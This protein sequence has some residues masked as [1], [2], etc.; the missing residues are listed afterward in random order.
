[1]LETLIHFSFTTP[2]S[3]LLCACDAAEPLEV[4]QLQ[5]GLLA[6]ATLTLT[7][8]VSACSSITAWTPASL[9]TDQEGLVRRLAL[10]GASKRSAAG[11]AASCEAGLVSVVESWLC[12]ISSAC[13]QWLKCMCALYNIQYNSWLGGTQLAMRERQALGTS[14]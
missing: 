4:H 2:A 8:G 10:A 12:D 13:A 14:C 3:S 6:A 5:A 7:A 9:P 11:A 1:M